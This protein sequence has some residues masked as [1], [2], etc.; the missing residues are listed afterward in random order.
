MDGSITV[1][2]SVFVNGQWA[3]A[4]WMADV[5]DDETGELMITATLA[6][7]GGHGPVV[8]ALRMDMELA[9]QLRAMAL[10]GAEQPCYDCRTNGVRLDALER[11]VML[12]SQRLNA[13]TKRLEA[14][15]QQ[16]RAPEDDTLL[17][18]DMMAVYDM[19]AQR[20]RALGGA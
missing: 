20:Q 15:E 2:G 10:S 6:G 7:E 17:T 8:T 13:A 9:R 18:V 4:H 5:V 19:I 14:L 12:H 3:T 16:D 11:D 1:P